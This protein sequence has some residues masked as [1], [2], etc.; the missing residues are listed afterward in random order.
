MWKA[1][2][3]FFW[4]H[5]WKTKQLYSGSYSRNSGRKAWIVAIQ[6]AVQIHEFH[7]FIRIK[8][9]DAGFWIQYWKKK[10]HRLHRVDHEVAGIFARNRNQ[11]PENWNCTNTIIHIR[12]S[13]V[14]FLFL[15]FC[16]CIFG[17]LISKQEKD[18]PHWRVIHESESFI[19]RSCANK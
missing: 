12:F 11:K 5:C 19:Q 7:V 17:Y 3:D 1:I 10:N 4:S 18:F 6:S 15:G 16:Q 13:F 9:R 8:Q 14:S 2:V